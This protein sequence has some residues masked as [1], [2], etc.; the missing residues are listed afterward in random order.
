MI[1][2]ERDFG[3]VFLTDMLTETILIYLSFA[4]SLFS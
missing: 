4:D 1:D 3:S 2:V